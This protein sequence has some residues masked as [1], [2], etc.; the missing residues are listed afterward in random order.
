ML[1]ILLCHSVRV[2]WSWVPGAGCWMIT[3]LRL[4][5]GEAPPE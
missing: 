5:R 2:P 3:P 1:S 4:R